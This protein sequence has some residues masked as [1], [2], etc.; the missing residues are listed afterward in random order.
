[1]SEIEIILKIPDPFVTA[2]AN[3]TDGR[4]FEFT[5]PGIPSIHFFVDKFTP[6]VYVYALM[7]LEDIAKEATEA[8]P[9]VTK[10]KAAV[11]PVI[12]P[13]V[14]PLVKPAAKAVATTVA[15]RPSKKPTSAGKT[16]R[17]VKETP[18]KTKRRRVRK[19]TVRAEPRRRMIRRKARSNAQIRIRRVVEYEYV[20]PEEEF[21]EVL[22]ED[23]YNVYE[24]EEFDDEVDED[25][26]YEEEDDDGEEIELEQ[27]IEEP[28]AEVPV[29]EADTEEIELQQSIAGIKKQSAKVTN[30]LAR[31]III[32]LK[33]IG[34]RGHIHWSDKEKR[35]V[36]R[37]MKNRDAVDEEAKQAVFAAGWREAFE[38]WLAQFN[39][40]IE[41]DEVFVKATYPR[42]AKI[43]KPLKEPRAPR[44]VKPRKPKVVLPSAA[45]EIK[46]SADPTCSTLKQFF[47]ERSTFPNASAPSSQVLPVKLDLQPSC[48]YPLALRKELMSNVVKTELTRR[49]LP[50]PAPKV[51]FRNAP[52]KQDTNILVGGIRCVDLTAD[53]SGYNSYSDADT[54]F[55]VDDM[56]GRFYDDDDD[57]VLM[58]TDEWRHR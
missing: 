41:S 24:E 23:G 32:M 13:A 49:I 1:M 39:L 44:Q 10:V 42:S 53:D 21:D 26:I 52:T 33:K 9:P 46:C 4:I 47:A 12:K 3:V 25:Y 57:V 29:P 50:S 35:A 5:N 14:K 27:A 20:E 6:I 48:D 55:F 17:V 7:G 45:E 54:E 30:P 15:K 36:S 51:E 40:L 37:L 38:L 31:R 28:V 34:V 18:V 2:S 58:T 43:P 11:K 22:D 16:V 8:K 19:V 56:D